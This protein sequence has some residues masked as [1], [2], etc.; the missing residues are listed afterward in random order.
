MMIQS[1]LEDLI[2]Q[3]LKKAMKKGNL[4]KFPMPP[5]TVSRPRRKG[6]GD[7]SCAL[8]LQIVREV[9]NALKAQQA[10]KLA[11]MQIGEILIQRLPDADFLD[12]AEVAKP[13]FINLYLSPA[14]LA[15]QASVISQDAAGYYHIDLGGGK[16]AV[17]YTHLT[18]PTK[19]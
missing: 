2:A 6:Q 11:P 7:Y 8:P 16:R 18:L 14:W 12:R 13:G 10:S 9:N 3:A 1:Q 17:S 15:R 19:A 4:P 5:V